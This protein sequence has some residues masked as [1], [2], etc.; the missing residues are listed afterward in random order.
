VANATLLYPVSFGSPFGV[1]LIYIKENKDERAF[2]S[3]DDFMFAVFM[4]TCF[5]QPVT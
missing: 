1:R 2:C 5:Q 3:Y 4:K